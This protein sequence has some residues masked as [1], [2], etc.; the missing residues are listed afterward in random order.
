MDAVE[1]IRMVCGLIGTNTYVVYAK[2][3]GQAVVIDPADGRAV[4]D[5]LK[6]ENLSCAAVLLTHGHFDHIAGADGV[7]QA[8]SCPVYVGEKDA[9]ML[10]D[11]E[12]NGSLPLLGAP[13]TAQ[14][15]DRTVRDGDVL[16]I[17]GMDIRVIGCP[18]HTP[19]G[20]SYLVDDAL[21]SGDTL[22]RRG[23]GRTDL[24]GG[25]AEA[26]FSSVLK[27]YDLPEDTKVFPGHGAPTRIGDEMRR[28]PFVRRQ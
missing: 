15:A 16:S 17:A 20:V 3:G 11:P 6:E 12:S 5:V 22:F 23:V 13:V 8:F 21:V 26:L 9:Q 18:G 27:L 10:S 19:G 7:K 25:N 14:N 4:L 1:V 2:G 24:Y 28:N